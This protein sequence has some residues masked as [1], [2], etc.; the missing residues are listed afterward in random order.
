MAITWQNIN[1][2][3]ATGGFLGM[4]EAREAI[5]DG[6]TGLNN[7]LKERQKVSDANWDNQAKNNTNAYMDALAEAKTPEEFQSKQAFLAQ[8]RQGFGAQGDAN[9]M[10]AAEDSRLALLQNRATADIGYRTAQDNEADVAK[11]GLVTELMGNGEYTKAGEAIKTMSARGQATWF[12]KLEAQ[13]DKDTT[14]AR[15]N[16]TF[17]QQLIEDANKNARAPKELE[18]LDSQINDNKAQA[19][20]RRNKPLE[21][22]RARGIAQAKIDLAADAKTNPYGETFSTNTA[23]NTKHILDALGTPSGKD[24][25][26]E[27][28]AYKAIALHYADPKNAYFIKGKGDAALSLPYNASVI[29]QAVVMT[30]SGQKESIAF[31]LGGSSGYG[32]EYI[33]RVIANAEKLMDDSTIDDPMVNGVPG[34]LAINKPGA[35]NAWARRNSLLA[36]ARDDAP[37]T[38]SETGIPKPN[39]T[40]TASEKAPVNVP[41]AKLEEAAAKASTSPETKAEAGTAAKLRA[42]VLDLATLPFTAGGSVVTEAFNRSGLTDFKLTSPYDAYGAVPFSDALKQDPE[43]FNQPVST[44][45]K[46]TIYS[47][48][49]LPVDVIERNKATMRA[50]INPNYKPPSLPDMPEVTNEGIAG[51]NTFGVAGLLAK[52]A[53]AKYFPNTDAPVA[54]LDKAAAANTTQNIPPTHPAQ[55]PVE[56]YSWGIQEGKGTKVQIKRVLDG[57]T[58]EFESLDGK[59]IPN[60]KGNVGRF[61]SS[62]ANETG[63]SWLG[64]KDQAMSQEAKDYLSTLSKDKE[65]TIQVTGQAN[66]KDTYK[67]R[68]VIDIEIDGVPIEIAMIR[69]GYTHPNT[70]NYSTDSQRYKDIMRASQISETE[71]TGVNSP[72]NRS[73][74]RADE[75]RALNTKIAKE[76]LKKA[77]NQ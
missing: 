54:A 57:D 52:A 10:R 38:R 71:R 39:D 45:Q 49:G 15:A 73:T 75:E 27:R 68:N 12:Q 48:G 28:D 46:P 31:G 37:I 77:L 2:P 17:S 18:L 60:A 20:A 4:R 5:N 56:K 41:V 69:A 16:V 65:V 42:N 55:K 11:A 61:G 76:K 43:M 1:A 70:R 66:R 62:D 13:K 74:L 3:Q 72:E 6:W 19:D 67:T 9:A 22:A 8:M 40:G 50:Q 58:V 26:P 29:K 32:P 53:K 21:E 51:L 7:I 63:K 36:A 14:Q 35:Y 30:D 33:K 24:A 64:T 25:G 34:T 59:P 47:N 44:G 23:V